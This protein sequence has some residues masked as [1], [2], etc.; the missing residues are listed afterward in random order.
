[1]LN[2]FSNCSGL[3]SVTIGDGVTSIGDWAFRDC[4]SLT[5]VHISDIAA[6][7]EISFARSV[8]GGFSSNPLYYAHHLYLGEKE[9]TD[10]VIPNSVTSIGDG[11]FY[12]CSGLTSVTIPNSVTSIGSIAFSECSGLTTVTIGIS[13]T[14]IGDWAFENCSSLKT[15]KV[16]VT[17]YCAF[18]NNELISLIYSN[19]G[20]PVQLIDSEGKEITEYIVPDGVTSIGSNAFRNCTGLTAIKIPC[21]VTSIESDAFSG[22][23]SLN[24]VKVPVTDY[25]TF[26]T[27]KAL[28]CIYSSLGKP[29]QLIDS[30]GKE[31]TEYIVPDGVTSIGSNAFR[32][33]TGLTAITIAGSVTSIGYSAFEYCSCLTSVTIS[34]SVT[35]I[36]SNAFSGCSSL[37]SIKVPVTD[38]STFCNNKALGCISSSIGKPVQ[39]IDSEEKEITEYIVPDGVTSIESSAFRNCTGL[40]AITIAGSVTSI[41]NYAFSGCSGLTSVTIG[42]S[43]TSL[44]NNAFSDCTSLMSVK[45]Y[46]TE[47]F[48][49]S[50]FTEETYRNGTLYVPAGTKDL[51]IRFDGWREFLKIEEMTAEPA[52]NGECATPRIYVVGKKFV[53][54]C[55][56]PG[57]EFESI[58][59][60]EEEKS[61]G[62]EFVMEN[63]TIKYTLTVYA[64]AE[65]YDRSQPA[66][67]SFVID[68]NDVNQDGAVDVADIST[69]ISTMAEK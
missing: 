1:M 6:W 63:K 28:G 44:G 21:S 20:K 53:Y 15:V 61:K 30:E 11:A 64:T 43:V 66:T 52:P 35:S 5:A 65:G 67:I 54:E 69:I 34:N 37:N 33:C 49:I 38:Y 51:Y 25:S 55:D 12:G 2:I 45:S 58:L 57:A 68:R 17:D 19:I 39:L 14:S 56:T 10:I 7:C 41:G 13:V 3:T 26:C 59:S 27:N 8:T 23:S 36:A 9:I 60:T 18:C 31:I 47:P 22:C 40:T 32:N 62:N 48:N 46:I 29:V 16:P 42:S 4:S 24:S 50:R